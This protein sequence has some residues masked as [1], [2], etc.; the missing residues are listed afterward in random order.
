MFSDCVQH[1]VL[2]S[3]H[4]V[5]LGS[6]CLS[7]SGGER[8]WHA[9]APYETLVANERLLRSKVLLL[10]D[11]PQGRQRSSLTCSGKQPLGVILTWRGFC[12]PPARSQLCPRGLAGAVI[13]V[14]DRPDARQQRLELLLVLGI[15]PGLATQSSRHRIQLRPL[16]PLLRGQARLSG[17]SCKTARR[18]CT[19][20]PRRPAAS[21]RLM[22]AALCAL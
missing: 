12:A 2:W 11:S 4:C 15:Q 14:Q 7:E 5:L 18:V 20:T 19:I 6:A 17:R 21:F 8:T 13:E 3:D 9:C 22:T 16:R 1:C 10:M